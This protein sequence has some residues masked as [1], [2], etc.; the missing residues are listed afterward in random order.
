MSSMR[1]PFKMR[2]SEK[3]ESDVNFISLYSPEILN[4]IQ[5]INIQTPLWNNTSYFV[6]SPG[7]GKTSLLRLFSPTILDHIYNRKDTQSYKEIFNVLKELDALTDQGCKRIGIYYLCSRNYSLLEDEDIYTNSQSKRYFFALLNVRMV[8]TT[9][10]S[11]ISFF[12]T[13]YTELGNIIFS[14]SFVPKEINGLKFPCDG[15]TL[16]SWAESVESEIC[17]ML[18][19]FEPQDLKVSGHDNLFSF[20]FLNADFFK[21]KGNKICDDFIFQLDD[22]HKLSHRQREYFKEENV[23]SRNS[24]T[25]WISERL[26]GFSAEELLGDNNSKK[27]DYNYIQ[28]ENL[29]ETRTN[30]QKKFYTVIA[31]KRAQLS[32]E[33][34]NSFKDYLEEEYLHDN[35]IKFENAYNDLKKELESNDLLVYYKIWLDIIDSFQTY[36]EKA[37]YLRAIKIHIEREQKKNYLFQLDK[38]EEEFQ[39][40][41]KPE[42]LKLCDSFLRVEY[43]IPLYF[44]FDK[45]IQMSSN[46]VE[47]F[48]SISG[49]LFDNII[50]NKIKTPQ[51]LKLSCEDQ[52][53]IIVKFANDKYKDLVHLPNGPYIKNL[54][55]KLIILAQGTTYDDGSSYRSVTGFAVA[56]ENK[57]GLFESKTPWYKIEKFKLLAE[58]IKT[59]IAYNVFETRIVTQGEKNQKWSVFYFNRWVCAFANL[60][61]NYGG[62]KK[63]SLAELNKNLIR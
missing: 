53:S 37:S 52:H 46:N 21:Y 9:L 54:L 19:S 33:R 23:E 38:T 55:D 47:Q 5:E 2:A 28:I 24:V 48:I 31:D 18:D 57:V 17:E 36:K 14:P 41:M 35:G 8:I 39:I 34:I 63:I 25:I 29:V 60:P 20:K 12:R 3:I 44:S 42:L 15:K 4:K 59:C 13:D 6:S 51:N 1:N 56:E 43:K 26:E 45:L 22:F 11:I 32:S 10:Q 16:F 58:V 50:L 62:W 27:R 49:D 61:L 7:A 40:F 30:S